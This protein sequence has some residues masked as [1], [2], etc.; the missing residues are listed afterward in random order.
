MPSYKKCHINVI[1]HLVLDINLALHL[2]FKYPARHSIRLYKA[3]A[4]VCMLCNNLLNRS[5]EKR[6]HEKGV[7][8][9][10]LLMKGNRWDGTN[11]GKV[12]EAFLW[13]CSCWI[14]NRN[15]QAHN[16]PVCELWHQSQAG[17]VNISQDESLLSCLSLFGEER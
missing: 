16:L 6:N 9:E 11:D 7:G 17:K 5:N 2:H 15:K 10:Y 1:L 8:V 14:Y 12:W 13:I 3:G 4:Y